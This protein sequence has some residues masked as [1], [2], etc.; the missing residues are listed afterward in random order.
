MGAAN[1]KPVEKESK[2]VST[3]KSSKETKAEA[4]DKSK[5]K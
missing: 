2:T 5:G 3:A 4:T 1:A